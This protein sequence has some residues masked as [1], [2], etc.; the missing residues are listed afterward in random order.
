MDLLIYRRFRITNISFNTGI[1][2]RRR[3]WGWRNRGR[4]WSNTDIV[5]AGLTG[6]TGYSGTDRYRDRG[7]ARIPNSSIFITHPPRSNTW[8][9]PANP[10]IVFIPITN[11]AGRRIVF[12]VV[13]DAVT[14]FPT[15]LTLPVDADW[16]L[17]GR[18]AAGRFN[19]R[20]LNQG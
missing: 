12:P 14:L 5:L 20:Q 7:T 17:A 4:R 10:F 11:P 2:L 16:R 8:F 19:R 13:S 3:S 15:S 1:T 9:S 18:T 6:R